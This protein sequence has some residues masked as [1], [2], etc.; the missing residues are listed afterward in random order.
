[1]PSYAE[2][3]FLHCHCAWQPR[4]SGPEAVQ[5]HAMAGLQGQRC[6]LSRSSLGLEMVVVKLSPPLS[7]RRKVIAGGCLFSRM[8]KPSSSCS[9]SFLWLMGFRQ[10][11]TIRIRLHVR[12]V[13]MTCAGRTQNQSQTCTSIHIRHPISPRQ[14][15]RCNA[16]SFAF[17]Q[18]GQEGDA[19][20]SV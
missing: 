12:A 1:M 3:S 9:I 4:H 7:F 19:S 16:S 8:P 5:Q 2:K 20:D 14:L 18:K 10:S 11:S 17:N 6:A 15:E 13:L